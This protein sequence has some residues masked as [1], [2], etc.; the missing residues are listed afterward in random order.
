MVIQ[1]GKPSLRGIECKILIDP[2]PSTFS[3]STSGY[4]EADPM[5]FSNRHQ[6][7]ST[8]HSLNASAPVIGSKMVCVSG[9]APWPSG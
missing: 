1:K 5:F 3:V 4:C 8:L 9:L 2:H 7:I 6:T